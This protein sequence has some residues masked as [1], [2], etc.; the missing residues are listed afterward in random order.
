L[1]TVQRGLTVAEGLASN[2]GLGDRIDIFEV[3][4]FVAL[5]LYEIAKFAAEGRRIAVTDLVSRYN[6]IVE[7]FETDPSLKIELKR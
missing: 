6:E 3:E 5:N 2:V 7:E 1:V 4:Q